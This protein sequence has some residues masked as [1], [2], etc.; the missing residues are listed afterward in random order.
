MVKVV[1]R[2]K[3]D[4]ERLDVFEGFEDL[5]LSVQRQRSGFRLVPCRD[6]VRT[7]LSCPLHSLFRCAHCA[8]SASLA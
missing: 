7:A 5:G 8:R 3:W 1:L 2:A 4:C 6:V